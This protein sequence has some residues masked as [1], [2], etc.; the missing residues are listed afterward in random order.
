VEA[1]SARGL[2]GPPGPRTRPVGTRSTRDL[3]GW[4]CSA[5]DPPG[6]N[7]LGPDLPRWDS[8]AGNLPGGE[9]PGG[10][11]LGM[12]VAAADMPEVGDAGSRPS[13]PAPTDDSR[14]ERKPLRA[15]S[16]PGHTLCTA[17]PGARPAIRPAPH[18]PSDQRATRSPDQRAT[19]HPTGAPSASPAKHDTTRAH[20]TDPPTPHGPGPLPHGAD[21]A[22]RLWR[23][24]RVLRRRV[25]V[26]TAH[27]PRLVRARGRLGR[28]RPV[29]DDGSPGPGG[30][31]AVFGRRFTQE[32]PALRITAAHPPGTYTKWRHL[33]PLPSPSVAGH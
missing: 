8:S 5:E 16:S 22:C 3:P 23:V 24:G 30:L 9:V 1:C 25:A 4:T 10:E 12:A 11:V 14:R 31:V 13:W 27:R 17:F 19:C 32:P 26:P 15:G 33:P 6:G 29:P 18:S 20:S 7:L 2:G 28:R 21:E